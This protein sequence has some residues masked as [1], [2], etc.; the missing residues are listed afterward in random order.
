MVAHS[1]ETI[2]QFEQ[3][4]R[5]SCQV[6]TVEQEVGYVEPQVCSSR[7]PSLLSNLCLRDGR[8]NHVT[9]LGTSVP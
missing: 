6:N 4:F 8:C 7:V 3:N 1:I 9:W 5:I 2:S